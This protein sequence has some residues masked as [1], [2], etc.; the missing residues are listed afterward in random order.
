MNEVRLDGAVGLVTGGGRGIGRAIALR[1]AAA[2]AEV[3]V[4]DLDGDAADRTAR[5]V[6]DT[7]GVRCIAAPGDVTT[8]SA[9]DEVVSTALGLAGHL[10]VLV[11]NAGVLAN[12]PLVEMTDADWQRVIDVHLGGAFRCARAAAPHLRSGGS[13]ITLSSGSA[14]GSTRGQV[15]YASAKSGVFGFT[16]TLALELAPHIRVNAVAPGAI[17]SEMTRD[18]AR[19]L[20][21][22]FRDYREEV[23][24][25]T[26]LGRLGQPEEI[27]DAVCFLASPMAG[28]ITGQVLRVA[29]GP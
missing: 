27:A 3:V 9:V 14:W 25:R 2:G 11:N 1:L 29:G 23:S 17:E 10:D 20:G 19:T 18:T 7:W 5:A 13:I 15:N 21:L 22:S 6:R 12:A 4:N 24:A 28:F 26:P 16:R 8:T